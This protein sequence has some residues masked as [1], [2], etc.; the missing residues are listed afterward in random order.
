MPTKLRHECE[1]CGLAA[2]FERVGRFRDEDYQELWRD[3]MRLEQLFAGLVAKYITA[4]QRSA[5][6]HRQIDALVLDTCP[7]LEPIP[8]EPEWPL[9]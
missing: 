1:R 6:L 3:Y 7:K 4:C 9:I 2:E 8:A 5:K